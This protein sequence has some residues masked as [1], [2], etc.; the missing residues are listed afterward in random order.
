[1]YVTIDVIL[2]SFNDYLFHM[3]YVSIYQY[4]IEF[5]YVRKNV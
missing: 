2:F 3:G 1:M 5:Y 4:K